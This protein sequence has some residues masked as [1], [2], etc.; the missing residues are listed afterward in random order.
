MFLVAFSLNCT[1]SSWSSCSFQCGNDTRTRTFIRSVT[2]SAQSCTR[3]STKTCIVT[4]CMTAVIE[5][6]K[7][8]LVWTACAMFVGMASN[9][10]ASLGATATMGSNNTS[11]L[12]ALLAIDGS[13]SNLI[14]QK[15]FVTDC[16]VTN[17]TTNPWLRVDFKKEYLVSSVKVM[18][19]VEKGENVTIRV[20][21]SLV[22]N[23]NDSNYC[24]LAHYEAPATTNATWRD[25]HCNP[26]VWGQYLNLQSIDGY[27]ALRV[28][29]VVFSYG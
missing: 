9:L 19:M 22:N 12:S 15:Q 7:H 2:T 17:Y 10:S 21:N 4:S 8:C 13:P 16:A 20:G 24:G 25:V 26:P 3:D 28:C 23:G 6:V 29:E 18:L 14:A 5:K 27:S 1:W 11:N